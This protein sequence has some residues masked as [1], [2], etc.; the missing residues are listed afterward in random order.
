[1]Q[2]QQDPLAQLRDIHL[3]EPIGWWLPAYGW[4]L[5]A[6]A[7][8]ACV[9]WLVRRVRLRRRSVLRF[10]RLELQQLE[11]SFAL[12]ADPAQLAVG[13]AEL[14]RRVAL[15]RYP[16]HEVAHLHGESWVAFLSAHHGGQN[17]QEFM[18]L[19]MAP[20]VPAAVVAAE[21]DPQRVLAATKSWIRRNAG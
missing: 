12:L 13:L 1:M 17:R 18:W 2:N 11:E 6:A 19:G 20:Y 9:W 14:L 10:A 5:V 3:P 16:R 4:W 15:T 21:V 8:I 7:G